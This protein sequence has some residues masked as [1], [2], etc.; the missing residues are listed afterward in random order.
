MGHV[1]QELA[2]EAAGLLQGPAALILGA[3]A[4]RDVADRAGDEHTA[5]RLQGAEADL[6]GE[7]GPVLALAVQLHPRA[8]AA[9]PRVGEEV[10][11]VPGVLRA[12]AYEHLDFAAEHL[13]ALVA[14][15]LLRLLVDQLDAAVSVHNDHRVRRRL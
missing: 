9:H 11:P 7:L 12:E 15:D 2:L 13:V 6:D 10:V 8:H 4:V 1:R 14:E 5:L 3:L